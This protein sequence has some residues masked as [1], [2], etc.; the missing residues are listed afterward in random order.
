[1][2]SREYVCYVIMS[3]DGRRTYAGSTN[4]LS[5]RLRQHDR[6]IKGGAR[7]TRGF[8]PCQLL[9]VVKGFNDDK[10][11]ALRM[12]WRLKRHRG[13]NAGIRGDPRW[14]RQV[15]LRDALRWAERSLP[16]AALQVVYGLPWC[17]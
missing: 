16:G 8:A 2:V 9:F 14:C 5:R 12:E 4:N 1:M 13:W 3:H 15:L 7:A 11:S 6:I 10:R 17:R